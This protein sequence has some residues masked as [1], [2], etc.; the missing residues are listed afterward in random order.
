MALVVSQVVLEGQ[1]KQQRATHDPDVLLPPEWNRRTL[2][3]RNFQG[4]LPEAVESVELVLW[5]PQEVGRDSEVLTASF[6][7]MTRGIFPS[8]YS[9]P[10]T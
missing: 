10:R 8:K 9:L 3:L 4:A 5:A 2:L 6:Q 1:T 7:P